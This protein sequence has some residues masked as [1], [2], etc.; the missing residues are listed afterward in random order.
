MIFDSFSADVL[1][2]RKGAERN[3]LPKPVEILFPEIRFLDIESSALIFGFPIEVALC[4]D[5]LNVQSWL[6][7][8][9]AKWDRL[10]WDAL[11]EQTHGI[12]YAL[13]SEKGRPAIE[14]ADEVVAALKGCT[15]YSDAV[16]FDSHWF[17]ML[18]DVGQEQPACRI[19]PISNL[20]RSRFGE[21]QSDE[22]EA[23]QIAA[24]AFADRFWPHIHRAGA[25]ALN[26]AVNFRMSV[27]DA[28]FKTVIDYD[29]AKSRR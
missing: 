23:R 1:R 2:S 18:C 9:N 19:E 17:N 10:H 14:V 6:I 24:T 25:D 12:S 8:P 5:A 26:L 22:D 21:S 16:P 20:F 7:A 29:N 13:L 11:A 15:V 3:G 27:D 4:D 28:F